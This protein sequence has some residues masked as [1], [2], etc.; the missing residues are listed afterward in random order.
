MPRKPRSPFPAFRST[1][2][3]AATTGEPCFLAEA[4]YRR[5]LDDLKTSADKF[6]CRIHAYVLMTNHVH[7]LVTPMREEAIGNMMQAL[8]RRYVHYVNKT[9]AAP[10]R[11]GK[12]ESKGSGSIYLKYRAWPLL[13]Y[14]Y[15][16]IVSVTSWKS[17]PDK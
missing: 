13:K 11:C 3:S 6:L 10:A 2:S 17:G 16:V 7:L 5:Y 14:T 15:G 1:S 8:G 4:D 9:Y 12:E